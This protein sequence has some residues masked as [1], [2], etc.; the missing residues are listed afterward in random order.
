MC[1]K[2]IYLPTSDQYPQFFEALKC[3]LTSFSFI[4]LWYKY[5]K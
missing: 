3:K 2:Y 4:A 1:D 5:D